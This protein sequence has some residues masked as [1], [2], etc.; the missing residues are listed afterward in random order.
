MEWG[1]LK[2]LVWFWTVPAIVALFFLASVRKKMKLRRFGDLDLVGRLV[3]SYSR[4]RRFLKRVLLTVAVALIVVALAQP[5][6]RKKETLVEH[7]GIDVI[8]AIDVSQS[9]MAKD[10]A[11]TRLDKAKL[12]L[13]GLVD[14]LKGDRIGIVAFA[15]DAL[16]QC[17]LTFDREAVKLFL[18]T[19]SPNLISYQGTAIGKA[20][21]TSLKAFE[22]SEKGYKA[23][24]LL[25]DGEDHEPMVEEAVSRAKQAGLPIYAIGIGTSDGSTLPDI[26]QNS[27]Y[28]KD[29]SG[30]VVLSKLNEAYLKDIA[31]K[32]GGVYYRSTRGE[33]ETDR[34]VRDLGFLSTKAMKSA[35]SVEYE[36][37]FQIV[38]VA[39]FILLFIEM[40]LS[41]RKIK[42]RD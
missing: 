35:W 23:L 11:P 20:I 22:L 33:L 41:E 6:F 13:S 17:P 15:G 37:N 10:I 36:E 24:I 14:K 7:R 32:T 30:E 5:H 8:I 3:A 12:E 40:G 16:I 38:L 28:L 29:R 31:R 34:L 42:N 9:M 25:T 21:L 27:G 18:T 26:F 2:N 4:M 39:A 19:V 1:Q